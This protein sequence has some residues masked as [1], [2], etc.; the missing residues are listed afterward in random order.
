MAMT[1][2]LV[3]F[4]GG[5]ALGAA[6]LA[7]LWFT[8][9]R[10]PTAGHPGLWLFFSAVVRVTLLLAGFYLVSEGRWQGIVACLF[11]FIVARFVAT[12]WPRLS[13]LCRNLLPQED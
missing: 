5:V 4:A 2:L 7:A 3:S 12:N 6:Y 1:S 8:V 9:R 13:R 10:I 11:G